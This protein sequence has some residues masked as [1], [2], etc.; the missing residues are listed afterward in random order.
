M[1]DERIDGERKMKSNKAIMRRRSFSLFFTGHT[2]RI[3][4]VAASFMLATFFVLV[5]RSAPQNESTAT[6]NEKV[7]TKVLGCL[8]ERAICQSLLAT[9]HSD[10]LGF[11]RW[12][13]RGRVEVLRSRM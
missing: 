1:D 9:S 3:V 8:C 5:A 10:A 7:A 4:F 12:V 6:I 2:R 11:P 13:Q